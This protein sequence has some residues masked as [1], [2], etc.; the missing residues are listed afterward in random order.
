MTDRHDPHDYPVMITS[1]SI[2]DSDGGRRDEVGHSSGR[3]FKHSS[4]DV[5]IP[6]GSPVAVEE[7]AGSGSPPAGSGVSTPASES[8]DS[9]HNRRGTHR[10]HRS[11]KPRKLKRPGRAA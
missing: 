1:A 10:G 5:R 2:V 11:R 6:I 4:V 8:A 7:T 9:G 3:M